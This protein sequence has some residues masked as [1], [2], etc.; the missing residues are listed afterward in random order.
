MI[1]I[2]EIDALTLSEW[3]RKDAPVRLLDVRSAAEF[4]HG[5]IPHGESLPLHLLPLRANDLRQEAPLVVYCRS[6]ARSA[7]ACAFLR[8]KGCN[9]IYNL[10]GGILDWARHG[11]PIVTAGA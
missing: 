6:G 1:S 11:L 8:Q 2:E 5:M 7:Q 3:L 10:R 9:N 4:A